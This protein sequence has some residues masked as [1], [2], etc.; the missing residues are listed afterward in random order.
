[1]YTHFQSKY[2]T[3]AFIEKTSFLVC[4][5]LFFLDCG[6]TKL[7]RLF[8]GNMPAMFLF[9]FQ[10]RCASSASTAAIFR[11]YAGFFFLF[12]SQHASS[13]STAVIFWHIA[14]YVY[15]SK[16]SIDVVS[17]HAILLE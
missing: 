8:A 14:C 7:L 5:L 17:F 4:L 16:R 2:N 13:G 11:Q 15:G 1:M 9:Q 10:S 12:Q 3:S 6:S